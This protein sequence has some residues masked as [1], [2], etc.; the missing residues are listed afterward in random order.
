MVGVRFFYRKFIWMTNFRPEFIISIRT[1]PLKSNDFKICFCSKKCI[2][3]FRKNLTKDAFITSKHSSAYIW[4]YRFE[5]WIYFFFK[6]NVL[7][8]VCG[9]YCVLMMRFA[10]GFGTD[11]LFNYCNSCKYNTWFILIRF[12]FWCIYVF[13]QMVWNM[14]YFIHSTT[15]EIRY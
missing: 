8:L 6:P 2:R 10:N 4:V 7:P 11:S 14:K 1:C 5:F 15:N 9:T 13:I 12:N 3:I